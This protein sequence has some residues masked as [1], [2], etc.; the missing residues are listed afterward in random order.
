MGTYHFTTKL[1]T[2]GHV[3]SAPQV[4]QAG[5]QIWR[6]AGPH[7]ASAEKIV[8]GMRIEAG[9]PARYTVPEVVEAPAATAGDPQ[10]IGDVD[11]ILARHGFPSLGGP[12]DMESQLRVISA[13]QESFDCRDVLSIDTEGAAALIAKIA[14]ADAAERLCDLR[15]VELANSAQSATAEHAAG[16]LST[17]LEL[18]RGAAEAQQNLSPSDR[19]RLRAIFGNRGPAM[20]PS[21]GFLRAKTAGAALRLDA[22]R[23]LLSSSAAWA[24]ALVAIIDGAASLDG[25]GTS[26]GLDR[27]GLLRIVYSLCSRGII[28]YDRLSDTVSIARSEKVD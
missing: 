24:R 20:A 11:A 7:M 25:L 17:R 16:D 28:D 8:R 13:L 23:R 22:R 27:V 10:S 12:G 2:L 26:L 6:F 14:A 4:R 9:E 1:K 15:E 18:L 3:S 5:P 21:L 19:S